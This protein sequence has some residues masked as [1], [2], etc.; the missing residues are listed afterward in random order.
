MIHEI[1]AEQVVC[2]ISM[3]SLT[4]VTTMKTVKAHV[5]CMQA[6]H[7]KIVVGTSPGAILVYN[8]Q[9]EFFH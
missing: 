2:S 8:L 7:N 4:R 9:E 6:D 3:E 5:K 1:E